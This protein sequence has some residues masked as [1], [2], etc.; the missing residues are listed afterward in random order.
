MHNSLNSLLSMSLGSSRNGRKRNSTLI[1]LLMMQSLVLCVEISFI[2]IHK[3][4]DDGYEFTRELNTYRKKRPNSFLIA[5]I[6]VFCFFKKEKKK[7]FLLHFHISFLTVI[8]INWFLWFWSSTFYDGG[9]YFTLI[10]DDFYG[11]FF[12]SRGFRAYWVQG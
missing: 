7:H 8:K 6:F 1:I 5:Q 9:N 3:Y 12:F 4:R 10:Y 11:L 2:V